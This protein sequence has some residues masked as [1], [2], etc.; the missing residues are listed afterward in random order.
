MR[1]VNFN[2]VHKINAIVIKR[3]KIKE[4]MTIHAVYI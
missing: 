4:F 2:D 3:F 1:H